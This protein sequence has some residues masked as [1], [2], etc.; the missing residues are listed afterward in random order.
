[1][2]GAL[3]AV[4]LAGHGDGVF[5]DWVGGGGLGRTGIPGEVVEAGGELKVGGE[6]LSFSLKW[7]L[8]RKFG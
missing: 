8:E 7:S 6:G 4:G 3:N 5:A 2:S 1:M